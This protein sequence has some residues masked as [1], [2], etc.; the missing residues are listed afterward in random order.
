LQRTYSFYHSLTRLDLVRGWSV[1]KE[2][3]MA[4]SRKKVSSKAKIGLSL[5]L[6]TTISIVL[7]AMGIYVLVSV[8]ATRKVPDISG[9]EYSNVDISKDADISQVY[10]T[11]RYS[12]QSHRQIALSEF[13][14]ENFDI[15]KVGIQN[16]KLNY[17]GFEQVVT[18]NVVDT[19]R[20]IEYK[21]TPGGHILGQTKQTVPSG[22]N[23]S[24]VV[25]EAEEGYYF[26]EWNDRKDN[27]I[28]KEENVSESMELIATFKKIEYKVVFYYDDGTIAREQMV[29][30]GSMPSSIPDPS[31]N[32]MKIYGK[33][34]IGWDQSYENVT[35]KLDIHP[36]YKKVATDVELHIT[37]DN[38][39]DV[40]LGDSD[41]HEKG[42]YP[43]DSYANI[44]VSPRP[45]RVFTG[46]SINTYNGWINIEKRSTTSIQ[47]YE[48]GNRI[49]FTSELADLALDSYRL[50]FMPEEG[51]AQ[52][53]IRAEFAYEE[54]VITFSN[55]SNIVKTIILP[56]GTPIAAHLFEPQGASGNTFI[57]WYPKDS[58]GETGDRRIE[59]S[60]IFPQ[61]AELVS[62]YTIKIMTVTFNG[63][64]ADNSNELNK[65]VEV[66]YQQK[67]PDHEM[68]KKVPVRNNYIYLGWYLFED[69][70]FT[71]QVIDGNFAIVS[72]IEAR[73][74]FEVITYNLN[75]TT[76]GAGS[77]YNFTTGSLV[78]ITKGVM[79]PRP[80][81]ITQYTLAFLADTGYSVEAFESDFEGFEEY[82]GDPCNR[83]EYT[84]TPTRDIN[85]TVTYAISYYD[86]I[87]ENG[88]EQDKGSV[89]YQN[90]D[91][92]TVVSNDT[93]IELSFSHGTTK[94]FRFEAEAYKYVKSI[95]VNDEPISGIPRNTLDYTLPIENMDKHLTI[96]VEY[97]ILSYQVT[98][99]EN[100]VNYS[101]IPQESQELYPR[102][103]NP[104]F[105]VS[106]QEGYYISALRINGT[107]VNLFSSTAGYS[108]SDLKINY[109]EQEDG[110]Q[111]VRVTSF[112]LEIKTIDEDKVITVDV[113]PI[114]YNVNI[115]RVGLGDFIL[116]T[117]KPTFGYN[118]S[119][120]I[121]A[122]TVSG[123]FVKSITVNGI[124]TLY[125]DRDESQIE[126]FTNI[127]QDLNIIF[128][129]SIQSY[130]VFFNGAGDINASASVA[131]IG[132]EAKRFSATFNE[133]A[134]S[135]LNYIITPDTGYYIYSLKVGDQDFAV[136]T[137]SNAQLVEINN[138][139]SVVRVTVDVRKVSYDIE[140][141][142]NNTEYGTVDTESGN[143]TILH[144]E[145][146]LLIITPS[147]GYYIKD[148][149]Y[150]GQN[151][152]DRLTGNEFALANVTGVCQVS[153]TFERIKYSV[154]AGNN[155][156]GNIE[157]TQTLVPSGEDILVSVWA[158]DGYVIDYYTLNGD[159]A[160]PA[161]SN[162]T[163]DCF[164]LA[165]DSDI[166]FS[167]YYKVYNWQ[168]EQT[169]YIQ[170]TGQGYIEGNIANFDE[171]QN[172][173]TLSVIDVIH[174]GVVADTGYYI[175]SINGTLNGGKIEDWI[176]TGFASG[177]TIS[178]V[179]EKEDYDVSLNTPDNGSL[180][181]DKNSVTFGE[182]VEFTF[183]PNEGY[184]LEYLKINGFIKTTSGSSY[185]LN[186][187]SE[188]INAEVGFKPK[189]YS[190]GISASANGSVTTPLPYFNSG[191]SVA[192]TIIPN[193]GF[194]LAS[195]IL[196]TVQGSYALTPEEIATINAASRLNKIYEVSATL[197]RDLAIAEGELIIN[198]TFV[199]NTYTVNVMIEGDG[200]VI[201]RTELIGISATHGESFMLLLEANTSNYI[202]EIIVNGQLI[203]LVT[204]IV[205]G[206]INNITNELISGEYTI[207]VRQ[208][209][210]IRI[211]FAED[212]FK[213][214]ISSSLNG[215]TTLGDGF[216]QVSVKT[217]VNV[218]LSMRANA[219]YHIARVLINGENVPYT[220][221]EM[222]PF[223]DVNHNSTNFYMLVD[224]RQNIS[225]QVIYER[226][227]YF[228]SVI[229]ANKS[230]NFKNTDDI[231]E[232]YGTVIISGYQSKDG[233]DGAVDFYGIPHGSSFNIIITPVRNKGYHISKFYIEWKPTTSSTIQEITPDGINP[234]GYVFRFENITNDINKI[235]VEFERDLF[236]ISERVISDEGEV[237]TLFYNPINGDP[238]TNI[239]SVESEGIRTYTGIEYG[240]QSITYL[241]SPIGYTLTSFIVNNFERLSYIRN[242]RYTTY[243]QSNSDIIVEYLINQYSFELNDISTPSGI[244]KGWISVNREGT[245]QENHL[246]VMHGTSLELVITPNYTY[247]GYAIGSVTINGVR[248][249]VSNKNIQL[250]HTITIEEDTIVNVNFTINTYNIYITQPTEGGRVTIP[251]M[252]SGA[253][254][255]VPAGD[256]E[257]SNS[258]TLT[259]DIYNGYR[260][261]EFI[262]N[263]TNY[264]SPYIEHGST[265]TIY[266]IKDIQYILVIYVRKTFSIDFYGNFDDDNTYMEDGIRV[267][268]YATYNGGKVESSQFNNTIILHFKLAT[269][270]EIQDWSYE[271]GG[272]PQSFN[273]DSF[274][275]DPLNPYWYT[276]TISALTGNLEVYATYAIKQYQITAT[277]NDIDYMQYSITKDSIEVSQATH[278]DI[279]NISIQVEYG[280]SLL[281]IFINNTIYSV[282]NVEDY[283]RINYTNN[284][285]TYSYA[286]TLEVIDEL[287]NN[288]D[289]LNIYLN[290]K[291]NTYKVEIT[292]V[293][294]DGNPS[295]KMSFSGARSYEHGNFLV[296]T[297]T[298]S[299]G[300][301]VLPV[302]PDSENEPGLRINGISY[303]LYDYNEVVQHIDFGATTITLTL[304]GNL[305]SN[306]DVHGTEFGS[307]AILVF[308][309]RVIIKKHTT[310]I[311]QYI[312]ETGRNPETQGPDA[313]TTTV[314]LNSPVSGA[315]QEF[316][317]L[318]QNEATSEFFTVCNFISSVNLGEPYRFAG[319]Q[320]YI[321]NVWQYVENNKNGI[322]ISGNIM[323]YTV[324][325]DRVFRAVYYRQY[326]AIVEV[327]P[328]YKYL[329]GQYSASVNSLVFKEYATIT[330]TANGT[331]VHDSEVNLTNQ[332]K[333]IID[334][335]AY[336]KL[337]YNDSLAQNP[338]YGV[339]YLKETVTG[340]IKQYT[341]VSNEGQ[342]MLITEDIKLFAAM[343]NDMHFTV[344]Q[345]TVGSE[346]AAS[347]GTPQYHIKPRGASDFNPY[348]VNPI[349]NYLPVD[350]FDTV[351]IIVPVNLNYRFNGLYRQLVDEEA[352]QAQNKLV[353][354]GQ[355]TQVHATSDG[356]ITET[357][358]DNGNIVY[359][360]RVINHS[361]YKLE[362]YKTFEVSITVDYK[363]QNGPQIPNVT[364]A[365][366]SLVDSGFYYN[367][368]YDYGAVFNTV[369]NSG[370]DIESLNQKYQFI[371]WHVR[372]NDGAWINLETDL[373][374]VYPQAT[375]RVFRLAQYHAETS[376]DGFALVGVI[377]VDFKAVYVPIY[378]VTISNS[379]EYITRAGEPFSFNGGNV[380]LTNIIYNTIRYN[381]NVINT[382]CYNGDVN[383]MQ[384]TGSYQDP[385]NYDSWLDTYLKLSVTLNSTFKF[386]QWEYSF[387]GSDYQIFDYFGDT[388]PTAEVYS[389]P[390]NSDI[391]IRPIYQKTVTVKISPVVFYEKFGERT[392]NSDY[393]SLQNPYIIVG[394]EQI[395]DFPVVL[396]FDIDIELV[397]GVYTGDVNDP[398][399]DIVGW[400]KEITNDNDIL[401]DYPAENGSASI[402]LDE[403]V[404]DMGWTYLIDC[405]YI[406]LWKITVTTYNSS[407]TDI[408]DNAPRTTFDGEEMYSGA[409]P[410]KS[411]VTRI[412]QANTTLYLSVNTSATGN[413][414][415]FAI[416]NDKL[417]E[418][419]N[420]ILTD[421][422][423]PAPDILYGYLHAKGN[424]TVEIIYRTYCTLTITG[425]MPGGAIMF[426]PTAGAYSIYDALG[427]NPLVQDGVL[428]DTTG[429]D[430]IV[431]LENLDVIGMNNGGSSY[432]SKYGAFLKG[433]DENE[434]LSKQN[435]TIDFSPGGIYNKNLVINYQQFSGDDKPFD[436][437]AGTEASPYSISTRKQLEGIDT[438]YNACSK[439]VEGIYF[440]LTAN[441]SML[442]WVPICAAGS[443][444]GFNGI[445]D[446]DNKELTSFT[447]SG[448]ATRFVGMFLLTSG[449]VDKH[450]VL[451][452]FTVRAGANTIVATGSDYVGVLVGQA[453]YTD[454]SY[455]NI[456][457]AN[458]K[459]KLIAGIVTGESVNSCNF[460]NVTVTGGT[461]T[462]TG[463]YVGGFAGHINS[464]TIDACSVS[465]ITIVSP[466]TRIGGFVGEMRST[467][468]IKNSTLSGTNVIG[469]N[470]AQ[471]IGGFVGNIGETTSDTGGELDNCIIN[472]V[473]L[474]IFGRYHGDGSYQNTGAGGFAGRN[475]GKIKGC[476]VIAGN[477]IIKASVGGGIVGVNDTNGRLENN[478]LQGG[479]IDF[480]LNGS[481]SRLGGHAGG[482]KGSISGSQNTKAKGG[483]DWSTSTSMVAFR[484]VN[485]AF[486]NNTTAGTVY[487]WTT[488]YLGG[489]VGFNEGTITGC[490]NA[491]K[492]IHGRKIGDAI[493]PTMHFGGIVGYTNGS[494]TGSTM[495]GIMRSFNFLDADQGEL[496]G[497][498]SEGVYTREYNY[499]GGIAGNKAGGSMSGNTANG[500]VVYF[501]AIKYSDMKKSGG[502]LWW[503]WTSYN[504]SACTVRA[505]AVTGVNGAAG[506]G[507]RTGGSV[508]SESQKTGSQTGGAW[509]FTND[510][511]NDPV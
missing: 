431:R 296:I 81:A 309:Y 350:S 147:S 17:G 120:N 331:S 28:R 21:A 502:A 479:L 214:A 80:D 433:M 288:I 463:D 181:A 79:D 302:D 272:I 45:S 170:I 243:V 357:T 284:N 230:T 402:T 499:L 225:I 65:A 204:N 420:L 495:S 252:N 384:I 407:A 475:S 274:A 400:Y 222:F 344:I 217:G 90:I 262:I 447:L 60:D 50:R 361:I 151:A 35:S 360:L 22:S 379:Y 410:A 184:E 58:E 312:I 419:T 92:G 329:E 122:Y 394:G 56:Y 186:A 401:P 490:T 435:T 233:A 61:D 177:S 239:A 304:S 67:I 465:G 367:G 469:T 365:L 159:T 98:L 154:T 489:I 146:D 224:I 124:T 476:K 78:S 9:L 459:A 169:V 373:E 235:Y 306:L 160:E 275:V 19:N 333:F 29:Q 486:T 93:Y 118:D 116:S 95:K 18:F 197:A 488:T 443:K 127:R 196:G 308:S 218:Q 418:V 240:I 301:H 221:R 139:M 72:N 364:N 141:N 383:E 295:D 219:G 258:V 388:G 405:R 297:Q 49:I 158:S 254:P 2:L 77:S 149:E 434:C 291:K 48:D 437:G 174:I 273:A 285:N 164:F 429:A 441:I 292:P 104:K 500:H 112:T 259:F 26:V 310:N 428:P 485:I 39:N 369:V 474:E 76:I 503:T 185:T 66:P 356:L 113:A 85:I 51:L 133:Y 138:L 37:L 336:M 82:K 108:T 91:G 215:T 510:S 245:L 439:G 193:V 323:T 438:Y 10:I 422:F 14:P 148:I 375:D 482:N 427:G 106:T 207:D 246:I 430:G 334:C 387:N 483:N 166:V 391:Y 426:M 460:N 150:N 477:V 261:D 504:S 404:E 99:P 458:V 366:D 54:S 70:Q 473:K 199:S 162:S 156:H 283:C 385:D 339:D 55:Y 398:G 155:E 260:I 393:I 114:Y 172:K 251:N 313:G 392:T 176:F 20:V 102:H 305:V 345:E 109:Q 450:A 68:P 249:S 226:N 63:A 368:R 294:K 263:G 44:V 208:D 472:V 53:E 315:Q 266:E 470:N 46:W 131:K 84:F 363:E 24:S 396:N 83:V 413:N 231:S 144:G 195:M 173:Y 424:R 325:A 314:N 389:V 213:V 7:I 216:N 192:I 74:R 241:D 157:F 253:S 255:T 142:I 374:Y 307:N 386:V 442:N 286:V 205:N 456:I 267:E 223:D 453:K 449:T 409:N 30:H 491:S 328:Q 289:S 126:K 506:D 4:K 377:K 319:Y 175:K 250:I 86:I 40:P 110:S 335:N 327:S 121:T 117:D 212:T 32:L 101:I 6:V 330:A 445:L 346:N 179:F 466:Y 129:F 446:G 265:H 211:V 464:C 145:S 163:F 347:G 209:Y 143:Y 421:T 140:V 34:F 125:Q 248:L 52:V 416:N 381:P 498:N 96:V 27:P 234:N 299:E 188:H 354:S 136:D 16:A 277:A 111:D 229:T 468:K 115:D 161:A 318:N 194:S 349:D 201:N 57:G 47:V 3:Y 287:L 497:E 123:Y 353:F 87:I 403:R 376:R 324:K 293:D 75:I 511:S 380:D 203:D 88:N 232:K 228:A 509:Y 178:I 493:G 355:W 69:G 340:G 454:F 448:V 268:P 36:I 348:P 471:R 238:I 444:G 190:I 406:K 152:T 71:S 395:F 64:G 198:P 423:N 183:S 411:S 25:A 8:G 200:S 326:E 269:G 280:Y 372:Y 191:D 505:R 338:T 457:N 278:F 415:K 316:I 399:Y 417:D 167:A 451:K 321:D 227:T 236:S 461:I 362:Y 496:G 320:E 408:S 462:V 414:P 62:K 220:D 130:Q 247:E 478:I 5:V 165:V 237:E 290:I 467:G 480:P 103:S 358:D 300:Y 33:Q 244:T 337:S 343:H 322:T 359:T 135:N 342:G 378:N 390:L 210:D 352:T 202:A 341:A 137:A 180:S 171:I 432:T 89:T 276:Y 452:N 311:K 12:D 15:S 38:R 189:S 134:G 23:G 371:G 382:V 242:N 59:D 501:I 484:M 436:S 332:F 264:W 492:I 487:S 73:P 370:L 351:K 279:I 303:T 271:M 257:W 41:L 13:T 31:S 43:W 508:S 481:L 440:K 132:E 1:I 128:T 397:P 182:S 11:I 100:Q 425:V 281:S 168:G 298:F 455:I 42:Y 119:L 270:Y 206:T 187:V 317:T 97:E 507:S 107:A 494:V 282:E 105:D 94:N 256:V 412:M 153:I